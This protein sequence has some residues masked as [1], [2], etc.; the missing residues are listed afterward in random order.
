MSHRRRST[1]LWLRGTVYQYRVRVPV[2]LRQRL[3][4]SHVN[5]SLRTSSYAEA[6]RMAR[7]VA[8]EIEGMFDATRRGVESDP[9]NAACDR[10]CSSPLAPSVTADT[11]LPVTGPAIRI[12]LDLLAS[13]IAE[14]LQAAP[15][16]SVEAAMPDALSG[17]RSNRLDIAPTDRYR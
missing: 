14:K 9:V 11:V 10:A 6:I 17:H 8:F 1:G 16:A 4:R 15:P 2:E 7:R 13:R 3:G 12:D 5:R